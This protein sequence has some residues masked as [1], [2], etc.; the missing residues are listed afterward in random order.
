QV[1]FDSGHIAWMMVSTAFVLMMTGPGLA[2][3]YGG[4]VRKKNILSVMMQ[5]LFLMGMNSVLWAVIGYS[6]AFSDNGPILFSHGGKDFS[7]VG[8]LDLAFLQGVGPRS[9]GILSGEEGGIPDELFMI[10]QMMF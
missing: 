1:D 3:F 9:G 4:L 10:F 5:C 6:L 8:G 7:F 2:L